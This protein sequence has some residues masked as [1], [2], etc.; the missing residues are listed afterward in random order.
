MSF[1]VSRF[2]GQDRE[3]YYGID[4]E[5]IVTGPVIFSALHFEDEAEAEHALEIL[6]GSGIKGFIISE[7]MEQGVSKSLQ[8]ATGKDDENEL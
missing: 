5:H 7:V 2:K 6:V 1:I 4:G 8:T 3:F